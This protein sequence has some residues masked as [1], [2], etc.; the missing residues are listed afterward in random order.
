MLIITGRSSEVI[1]LRGIIVAPDYIEKV[2]ESDARVREAA[3]FTRIDKTGREE[4]WAAIV[5]RGAVDLTDI[6]KTARVALG[7]KTPRHLEI[8]DTMP[9][10][11]TGKLKRLALRQRFSVTS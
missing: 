2:L 5:P 3:V 4:I 7:D 10:T 8:V 6:L 9:R 11:E 1:N